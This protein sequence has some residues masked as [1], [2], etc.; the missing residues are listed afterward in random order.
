MPVESPAAADAI[1]IDA[2]GVCAKLAI[3]IT[4]L[5]AM[6]AT[7][8]FPLPPVHLGRC[9]RWRADELARW[10]ALGCPAADRWRMLQSANAGRR[11]TG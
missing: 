5:K 4:H 1:L 7:G 6:R 3:G 2:R 11:A 8:K 9:I 10:C